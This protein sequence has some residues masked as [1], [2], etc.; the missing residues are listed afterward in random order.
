VSYTS[1]YFFPL[2]K[3]T[4]K[5][6]YGIDES[7]TIFIMIGDHGMSFGQHYKFWNHKN[8]FEDNLRV[9]N[10][11]F[12]KGVPQGKIVPGM[13][14]QESVLPSILDL[15]GVSMPE[16]KLAPSIFSGIPLPRLQGCCSPPSICLITW[17]EDLKVIEWFEPKSSFEVFDPRHDRNEDRELWSTSDPLLKKRVRLMAKDTRQWAHTYSSDNLTMDFYPKSK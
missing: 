5:E 13:W 14:N 10:L 11:W 4:L 16:I 12:G 1:E 15:L 7:N 9:F 8:P 2:L 3:S 17:E 6:N